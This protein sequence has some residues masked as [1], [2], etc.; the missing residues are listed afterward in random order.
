MG[1]PPAAWAS[2]CPLRALSTAGPCAPA[3]RTGP[4]IAADGAGRA[5]GRQAWAGL[6]RGREHPAVLALEVAAQAGA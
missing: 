6:Q 2:A 5:Q 1:A 3:H 4:D